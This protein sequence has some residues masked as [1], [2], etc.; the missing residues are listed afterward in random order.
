MK[1]IV[2]I[3]AVI[4]VLFG[5]VFSV[6]A[7]YKIYSDIPY[8]EDTLYFERVKEYNYPHEE[9]NS[10]REFCYY[11]DENNEEPD[12]VLMVC[13]IL[14]EP[15]EYRHG[16]L[17]GDRALY[18]CS[19]PGLANSSTG[20]LV[21]IPRTDTFIDLVNSNVEHIIELCPDFVQVIEENEIGRL[22]GDVND[23]DNLD[24]LD[25]TYIQCALA[26]M[27]EYPLWAIW[28]EPR[29]FSVADFDRDGGAS[30]LDATAIQLK[31]AGL[32][33]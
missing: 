8:K 23:D 11:S 27:Y 20:L 3:M 25:V 18:T 30:I 26:G 1:K 17:V 9:Y 31:L 4:A 22:M 29:I 5:S 33:Y 13:D 16:A 10:Y 32:E 2:S 24:I 19:G 15:W 7:T 12:W 6:S 28:S 21:Y 14:P